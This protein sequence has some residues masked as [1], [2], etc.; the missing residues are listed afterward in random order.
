MIACAVV[1][2]S[3]ADGEIDISKHKYTFQ[4][5]SKISKVVKKGFI[6]YDNG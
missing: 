2:Y 1:V 3:D 6:L 5:L 4:Y